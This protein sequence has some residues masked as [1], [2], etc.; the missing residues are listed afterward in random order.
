MA[1]FTST[2]ATEWRTS[3]RASA[4]RRVSP[5][6]V[7]LAALFLL[8]LPLCNPGVHEDGV[9]HYALGRSLHLEH[10]LDFH[11]DWLLANPQF[12]LGHTDEH[13]QI[14]ADNYSATR[15][16]I[17]HYAIGVAGLFFVARHDRFLVRYLLITF[18]VHLYVIGCYQDWHGVESLG[19][20]SFVS[21]TPS[22]LLGLAA[23]FDRLSQVW[24]LRRATI[25]A[26]I[27]VYIFRMWNFGMMYQWGVHLIPASGPIAVGPESAIRNI[28][29]YPT[30]RGRLMQRIEDED[31]KQL[32]SQSPD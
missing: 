18:A 21:L 8:S 30:R 5:Y 4:R 13:G 32:K 6:Q 26:A 17:N 15:H 3:S 14:P 25:V 31:I 7:C 11:N 23:L 28:E 2:A 22:F 19:N 29:N 9:A 24:N 12:R 27:C 16:L 10:R 20:R 1:I